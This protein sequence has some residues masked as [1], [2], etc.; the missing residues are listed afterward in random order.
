MPFKRLVLYPVIFFACFCCCGC[1]IIIDNFFTSQ[2]VRDAEFK[3]TH[4]E[5]KLLLEE[6][7]QEAKG[8]QYWAIRAQEEK[9][10]AAKFERLNKIIEKQLQNIQ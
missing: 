8:E 5:P 7:E 2:R 10:A 6:A 4:Q 9:D 3:R 1:E